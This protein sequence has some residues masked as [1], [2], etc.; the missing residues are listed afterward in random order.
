M[1]TGA[2][3]DPSTGLDEQHH[4]HPGPDMVHDDGDDPEDDRDGGGNAKLGC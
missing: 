2:P 4:A 3:A 1:E